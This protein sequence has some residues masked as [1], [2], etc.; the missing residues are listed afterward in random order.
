MGFRDHPSLASPA[1]GDTGY[2]SPRPS[3]RTI[4]NL[5]SFSA[6]SAEKESRREGEVDELKEM[7]K[8]LL[9]Y[10]RSLRAM[11][12]E[13]EKQTEGCRCHASSRWPHTEEAP[14]IPQLPPRP[15]T[16]SGQGTRRSTG[17]SE[18]PVIPTLRLESVGK[19]A[20]LSGDAT[21]GDTYIQ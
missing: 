7:I 2:I 16:W 18:T 11:L 12:K 4:V 6:D 19:S 21:L 14:A 15:P 17:C 1:R 20:W 5:D 8:K 13:S 3:S 10:N 9:S